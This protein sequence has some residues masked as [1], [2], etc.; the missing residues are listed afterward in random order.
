MDNP[1]HEQNHQPLTTQVAIPL[2]IENQT[3]MQQSKKM[4]PASVS[5]I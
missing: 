1:E 4:F 3:N 5:S 2:W